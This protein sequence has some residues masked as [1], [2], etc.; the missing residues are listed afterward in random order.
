MR[1]FSSS[2]IVHRAAEITYVHYADSDVEDDGE[3]KQRST[4]LHRGANEVSNVVLA[5][6]A[7]AHFAHT[8]H[9][10]QSDHGESPRKRARLVGKS[11][12]QLSFALRYQRMR[13]EAYCIFRRMDIFHCCPCR[14]PPPVTPKT[15]ETTSLASSSIEA[16]S[17]TTP[18]AP[19][20]A[21]IA[22]V[23]PRPAVADVPR[24][25]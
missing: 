12:T 5:R 15:R 9:V 19:T 4:N 20:P 7:H 3:R 6:H 16:E 2:F 1:L 13:L 24:I 17:T 22:P 18:T 23:A 21:T 10:S 14:P 8:F 11:S 25:D